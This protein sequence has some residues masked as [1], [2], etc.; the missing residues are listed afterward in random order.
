MKA[1]QMMKAGRALGAVQKSGVLTHPVLK[2]AAKYW[3]FS[4]PAGMALYGK[5]RE[6]MEQKKGKVKIHQYFADAADVVGPILTLVSV[7][8]LAERLQDQGKLDDAPALSKPPP[9]PSTPQQQAVMQTP[10]QTQET[11]PPHLQ[12]M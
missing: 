3:W 12:R 4:L 1:G 9:P 10:A 6:R 11:P 7:I 5:I 2:M 8:E